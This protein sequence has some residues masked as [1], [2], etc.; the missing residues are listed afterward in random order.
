MY[1][2]NHC[3]ISWK[4]LRKYC[5]ARL[6]C[7]L[8]TKRNQALHLLSR[9]F[10]TSLHINWYKTFCILIAFQAPVIWSCVPQTIYF[11]KQLHWTF[12]CENVLPVGQ[13][14]VDSAWLFITLTENWTVQLSLVLWVSPHSFNHSAFCRVNF[15]FFYTNFCFKS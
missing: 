13:V 4:K 11:Q 7:G 3:L 15:Q 8:L 5:R 10:K 2:F 14:K 6:Q 1:F 9:Q 12:I